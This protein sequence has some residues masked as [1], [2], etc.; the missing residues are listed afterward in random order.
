ML[1]YFQ[2][3]TLLRSCQ[4]I[5]R[6][7]L[8]ESACSA[9]LFAR[10]CGDWPCAADQITGRTS[11][12]P[13]YRPALDGAQPTHSSPKWLIWMPP[14]VQVDWRLWYPLVKC[15]LIS[16]LFSAGLILLTLMKS[17]GKVLISTTSCED[18]PFSGFLFPGLTCYAINRVYL[19]NSNCKINCSALLHHGP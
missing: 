18:K 9:S 14:F 15:C 5:L 12:S 19:R 6:N 10:P 3:I 16:G 1:P 7:T 11:W 4:P 13:V 2:P 8:R 17:A